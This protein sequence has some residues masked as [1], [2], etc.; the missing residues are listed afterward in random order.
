MMVDWRDTFGKMERAS[1]PAGTPF[2]CVAQPERS[3]QPAAARLTLE[4]HFRRELN[5][6]RSERSRLGP[7]G[8][9]IEV[10]V[11]SVGIELRVV[12]EVVEFETEFDLGP[13]RNLRVFHKRK[14]KIVPARTMNDVAACITLCADGRC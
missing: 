8:A 9:G 11:N 12:E 10:G 5:G 1:H 3:S 13:L 4:I 7:E 6:P 14:V 2:V